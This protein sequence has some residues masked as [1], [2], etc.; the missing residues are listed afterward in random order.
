MDQIWLLLNINILNGFIFNTLCIYVCVPYIRSHNYLLT[1]LKPATW[2]FLQSPSNGMRINS[3]SPHSITVIHPWNFHTASF[4]SCSWICW[5]FSG[6]RNS[7]IPLYL[8]KSSEIGQC[9]A[10]IILSISASFFYKGSKA[11][12]ARIALNKSPL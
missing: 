7:N 2:Y 10:E 4:A 9:P 11:I 3:G 8:N 5:I 1:R 12:A 6:P